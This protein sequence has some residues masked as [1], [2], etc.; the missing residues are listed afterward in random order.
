MHRMF[1]FFQRLAVGMAAAVGLFTV[2]ACGGGDGP[3]GPP[4]QQQTG[5]VALAISDA[6]LE[7]LSSFTIDITGATL[8]GT[9]STQNAVV[10]P[11][12]GGPSTISVDLLSVQAMSQL[13]AGAQIPAGTYSH[14]EIQIS[15]VAAL[16]SNAVIQNI[17]TLSNTLTGH[18]VPQLTVTGSTNHTI[19]LEVDLESSYFDMGGNNGLLTSALRVEV[20]SNPVHA[21]AF[22][23]VVVSADAQLD[24]FVCDLHG[25]GS[26]GGAGGVVTVK[27]S[28]ATD[29]IT[30]NPRAVVSGSVTPVSTQ[31]SAGDRV[32]VKGALVS[33]A[34]LA[35]S[36]MRV[37]TGAPAS[38]S[39]SLHGTILA[40]DTVAATMTFKVTRSSGPHPRPAKFTDI[41]VDASSAVVIHG[42][43]ATL[44]DLKAGNYVHVEAELSGGLWT[45]SL[46]S[47]E[48]AFINGIAVSV[49]ANGGVQPGT[50][51]LT[52]TPVRVNGIAVAELGAIIPGT[53]TVDIRNNA[54]V[55]AND[56]IRVFGYFD[57]SAHLQTPGPGR[58]GSGLGPVQRPAPNPNPQPGPQPG[59]TPP[60]Q[61][62]RPFAGTVSGN[63]SMNA[64]GG[65]ILP[66]TLTQ[67]GMSADVSTTV[68]SSATIELLSRSGVSI[69]SAADALVHLN[70][71]ARPSAVVVWCSNPPAGSSIIADIILQIVVDMSGNMPSPPPPP[72]GPPPTPIV[73]TVTGNL[74]VGS[75]AVVNAMG[76]V[77][78]DLDVTGGGQAGPT[79]FVTATSG[80]SMQLLGPGGLV[81]VNANDC[82]ALLNSAG[83]TTM[84]QLEGTVAASGAQFVA[85]IRMLIVLDSNA[86]P[87]PAP[88]PVT[89]HTGVVATGTVA[90]LDASGNVV[91]DL[92]MQG[93]LGGTSVLH[94][95]VDA[96]AA[97]S[98]SGVGGVTVVSAA[99][100]V[101]ALNATPAPLA[102]RVEG[103][104]A[105]SGG[106]FSADMKLL[107]HA[108][109][110]PPPP[111]PGPAPTVVL[112]GQLAANSSAVITA[113][114][115]LDFALNTAGNGIVLVTVDSQALMQVSSSGGTSVV[116]AADAALAI[117]ATT[118]PYAI[119]VEGSAAIS[120]GAFSADISLL[121]IAA[122][123]APAPPPPPPAPQI[124]LTGTLALGAQATLTA[125]GNVVFNM[126][127][128]AHG[129]IQVT[130]LASATLQTSTAGGIQTVTAAQAAVAIN[131]TLAPSSIICTGTS[132]VVSGSFTADVSM[133]VV[134]SNAPPPAPPP[135]PATLIGTVTGT[136]SLNAAG[137]ILFTLQV[138]APLGLTN[139]SVSVTVSGTANLLIQSTVGLVSQTQTVTTAQALAALNAN[140]SLVTVTGVYSQASATFT[141]THELR[142]K[143]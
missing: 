101:L 136:A 77:E 2:A 53:L 35:S 36:V 6:P 112:Y 88:Q 39:Y 14:I 19:S 103:T 21:H 12:A 132:G 56:R 58:P 102:V 95:T 44:A 26:H 7:S 87:P 23:G 67:F 32:V 27:C 10:F 106:N 28:G 40:T 62:A 82:A 120:S 137:N 51:L 71:E 47:E 140:P 97:M 59:P 100:A 42:G 55:Q 117:N 30:L 104:A 96:A 128:Q 1:T 38:A 63:A 75:T 94:V 123:Q 142:I 29:F 92:A 13:I 85:D 61:G 107:I 129:T 74:S 45:A 116:T 20:T 33:G 15:G 78:F 127:H 43:P 131:A 54:N 34:V 91:F 84:I 11:A 93:L 60:P 79:L 124:T 80:A 41:T 121:V 134:A 46:I 76:G 83:A 125:A 113:S 73:V 24:T 57:G 109:M 99:D 68:T 9:G 49:A 135:P 69:I 81:A 126:V 22:P 31:V 18:F 119:K 66:M 90:A 52:F 105:A 141:A 118:A 108:A 130:A 138:P 115:G 122:T 16:D 70:A 37:G 8:H 110:A 133:M 139:T 64:S 4:S 17:T 72:A 48:P 25:V 3:S 50:S 111:P 5:S 98:V 89:V 86:P 143:Q 114:G 65:I